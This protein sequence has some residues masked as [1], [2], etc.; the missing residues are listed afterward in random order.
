MPL[1]EP[2]DLFTLCNR[3]A[4][5]VGGPVLIHD[6]AWGVVAYSTLTQTM[7]AARL[8]TILRRE[9]QG[10]HLDFAARERVHNLLLAGEPLITVDP[11]PPDLSRRIVA[12]VMVHGVLLGSIWVAESAGELSGDIADHLA[13]A[14]EQVA[15]YLEAQGTA[16]QRESERFMTMLLRGDGQEEFLLQCLGI[17]PASWLCVLGL[18]HGENEAVRQRLIDDLGKLVGKDGQPAPLTHANDRCY[19]LLSSHQ[20]R[21]DLAAIVASETER[22]ITHIDGLYVASGRITHMGNVAESRYDADR[23][24][25]YLCHNPER[26]SASIDEVRT[27]VTLMDLAAVLG[28]ALQANGSNLGVLDRLDP[29]DRTEAIR[30]LVVYFRYMGNITEAARDLHVHPNTLRYRMAKIEDILGVDLDDYEARM[31]LNVE[32]LWEKYRQPPQP[33]IL[34]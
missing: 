13:I 4:W 15:M 29:S 22:F 23:V 17:A 5:Q 10:D 31:L 32:L 12:P 28:Q 8:T 14:A 7:D 18:W 19:L 9:V 24:L 21:A 3:L 34:E 25:E 6:S 16:Q 20:S 30:T 1:A 11:E 2:V 33:P 27:G 26:R